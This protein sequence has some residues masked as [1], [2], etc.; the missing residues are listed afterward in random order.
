M[1]NQPYMVL[2]FNLQV[3]SRT[4]RSRTG[5][6]RRSRAVSNSTSIRSRSARTAKWWSPRGGRS[7][8]V[9]RSFPENSSTQKK[10]DSTFKLKKMRKIWNRLWFWGW[11]QTR[12]LPLEVIFS[13]HRARAQPISSPM[14]VLVAFV[15]RASNPFFQ[16]FPMIRFPPCPCPP[17]MVTYVQSRCRMIIN[18]EKTVLAKSRLLRTTGTRIVIQ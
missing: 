7:D 3:P 12:A 1:T 5:R 10:N 4:T 14:T 15:C 8:P 18:V 9:R 11:A 16:F 2:I 13:D 6:P 17:H